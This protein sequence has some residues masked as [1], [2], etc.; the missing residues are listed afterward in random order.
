MTLAEQTI[1]NL[2]KNALQGNNW[3]KGK[4]KKSWK[5]E[6]KVLVYKN[7]DLQKLRVLIV[8]TCLKYDNNKKL[9]FKT[10]IVIQ[11]SSPLYP[12]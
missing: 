11:K 6:E 10:T 2:E 7:V 8:L 4:Y 3:I 5:V 12:P 1:I 9:Y